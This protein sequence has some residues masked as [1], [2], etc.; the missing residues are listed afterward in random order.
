MAQGV[1]GLSRNNLDG[2][3][4]SGVIHLLLRERGNRIIIFTQKCTI[5]Q[6]KLPGKG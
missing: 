5:E 4:I 6:L 3:I 2:L 1:T